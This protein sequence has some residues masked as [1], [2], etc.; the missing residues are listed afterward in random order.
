MITGADIVYIS[1]IEWNFLWQVH[2]EVA[3]R[4]ARVGNRIL[5]IELSDWEI[6]VEEMSRLI[7]EA[8][9]CL[10]PEFAGPL[11]PPLTEREYFE[12]SD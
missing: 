4:L 12:V 11:V 6:R 8:I 9:A 3:V 1:S 5:Y 10:A 2:Q 7:E